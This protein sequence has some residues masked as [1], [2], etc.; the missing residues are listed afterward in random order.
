MGVQ[1]IVLRC[2]KT[3]TLVDVIADSICDKFLSTL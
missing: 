3:T 2:V 1:T